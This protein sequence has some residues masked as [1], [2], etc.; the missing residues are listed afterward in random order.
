MDEKKK[1]FPKGI[2]T[3]TPTD[4]F[5]YCLTTIRDILVTACKHL[6]L[7]SIKDWFLWCLFHDETCTIPVVPLH[8]HPSI[9]SN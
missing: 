8:I 7:Y 1:V 2:Q 4:P 5:N 6:T 9:L 3:K